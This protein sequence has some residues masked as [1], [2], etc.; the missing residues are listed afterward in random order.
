MIKL[1][2]TSKPTASPA[3]SLPEKLEKDPANRLLSRG[4]RYPARRRADPRPRARRLR[5][6][7][8]EKVGGPPVKPYQPEGIWEAV[9]MPQSNTRHYKQDSGEALYRR[10]LY[11]FWKRTA[12]P[13][14]DGDPQRPTR[15]VTFCV[16]RDRTNTPLQALAP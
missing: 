14:H 13:P 9:A 6:A 1:M 4:P 10:S 12:A 7:L 3:R 5:P 8:A 16:R 15:E 2:V 11:T